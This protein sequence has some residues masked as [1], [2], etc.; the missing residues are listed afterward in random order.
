MFDGPSDLIVLPCS[1]AGTITSFVREKLIH[2]RI[3]YPKPGMQLGDVHVLPFEGG[4]NI[5]QFV[6]FAASVEGSHSSTEAIRRIGVQLGE[7][8]RR[9][10]TVRLIA[11]PLLG[12]GAGGLRS[13]VV[14]Q[15]L[16]AG[17]KSAADK[18]ASL[19]ISVLHRDVLSES[20]VRP[21]K[22]AGSTSASMLPRRSVEG[23]DECSSATRTRHRITSNGLSQSRPSYD[24]M[25]LMLGSMRGI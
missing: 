6:A 22:C 1:T 14:V 2:H 4:E 17:F 13:E 24:K 20:V 21:S 8:T 23:P 11:A 15:S 3:S 12:A 10:P 5:A 18:D 16:S 25:G 9:G 19:T 7:C